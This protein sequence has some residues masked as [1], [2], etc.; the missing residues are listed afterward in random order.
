MKKT[1]SP[2]AIRNFIVSDTQSEEDVLNVVRL[3]EVC[4]VSCKAEGRDPGLRPVPLFESI[5]SL[6]DSA[7]VMKRLWQSG[8][9]QPL[10]ESWGRAHEVM[11]GYSDSNKDGGMLTSTWELHKAQRDLHQAAR[12]HASTCTCFMGAAERWG[13]EAARRMPRFLL[14]RPEIFQGKFASPNRAKS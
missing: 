1:Q 13:V 10:L 2:E 14:S 4:G 9:Y 5:A 11:L 6:R 7:A 12:E 3:A 8:D